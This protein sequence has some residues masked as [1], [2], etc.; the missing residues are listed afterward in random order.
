MTQFLEGLDG[1]SPRVFCD[2]HGWSLDQ[3]HVFHAAVRKDFL[4]FKLQIQ[5]D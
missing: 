3:V 4:N 2:I 5:H 1:F